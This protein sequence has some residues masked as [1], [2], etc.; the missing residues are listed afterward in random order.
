MTYCGAVGRN[1]RQIT[2][3]IRKFNL[4][5]ICTCNQ[6]E[7]NLAQKNEKTKSQGEHNQTPLEN[8]MI[9]RSPS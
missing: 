7:G 2:T 4:I 9:E 6:N 5:Q 3:I 1:F 8:L